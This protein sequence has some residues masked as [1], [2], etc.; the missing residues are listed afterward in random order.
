[1]RGSHSGYASN[2]RDVSSS[3]DER[4]SRED[5]N[6]KDN[7]NGRKLRQEQRIENR[8]FTKVILAVTP[9]SKRISATVGTP[10]TVPALKGLS[11]TESMSASLGMP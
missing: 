2:S 6:R 1:M 11:V 9:A 10:V 8:N 3:R 5:R 7:K 4:N